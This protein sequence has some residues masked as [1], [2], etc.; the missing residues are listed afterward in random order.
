MFISHTQQIELLLRK[1]QLLSLKEAQPG[2]AIE[3]QQGV[4]WVTSS[5]EAGDHMLRAGER[6]QPVHAG[7]VIIQA[8]D[9]AR[10]NIAE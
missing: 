8:I 6:Y 1:R 10:L 4:I 5:G 3:C 9:D 7:N 2:M